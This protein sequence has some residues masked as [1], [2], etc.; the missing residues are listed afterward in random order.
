MFSYFTLDNLWTLL[1]QMVDIGCVW[2]LVYYCLRIVKN[3]SRTIQIFKGVLL[4]VIIRFVATKVGLH[5]IAS[6]ADSIMN[7]GVVAIIIIFQPEI[8]SI[9]EKIGKTSVFS[10]I[11]TL[12]INERENLVNELVKACSEMSKTKTGALISIE[13]G[14][15]LSDFIK[16]GTSMN[17]VVSSELLCSI[18]QY[19][20]PLH[21]GAVII[22]G[23][24]IA[25][26][27]AYFPPTTRELPTSYGARHRAA[28][29]ISEITDSITIVVSEETG[30]ISIAQNG[31]LTV[32][33][34]ASLK[35]FLLSIVGNQSTAK[36]KEEQQKETLKE[37]EAVHGKKPGVFAHY[38]KGKGRKT[39][40]SSETI[41]YTEKKKKEESVDIIQ[42]ETDLH[43]KLEI[44]DLAQKQATGLD[45]LF[46]NILNEGDKKEE[47]KPKKKRKKKAAQTKETNASKEENPKKEDGLSTLA[48]MSQELMEDV[49]E[50]E[51]IVLHYESD[52]EGRDS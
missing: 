23:V 30:N 43:D 37:Q 8:R 7:W 14:H 48:H 36:E 26:A 25:C 29:G 19:G 45:Q 3:N 33:S 32:M 35:E 24:K 12:T 52:E 21:D 47:A 6:L 34:E 11:S 22:Q 50:P 2:A 18:F 4:I 41:S 16:T 49:V 28:V 13:Q 10:G 38:F 5:T 46:D 51:T 42:P 44:E 40:D 20:T 39:K 27:A 15:S 9:L 31:T 1:W 17:S